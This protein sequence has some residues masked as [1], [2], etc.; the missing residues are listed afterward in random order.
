MALQLDDGFVV[1]V[2][3]VVV[4]VVDLV[5]VVDVKVVDFISSDSQQANERILLKCTVL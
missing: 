2:V 5:V 4:V 1:V 3:N